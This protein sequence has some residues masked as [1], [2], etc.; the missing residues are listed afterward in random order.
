MNE[1]MCQCGHPAS[2]HATCGCMV[3]IHKGGLRGI[4]PCLF[5]PKAEET[6]AATTQL[7][8]AQARITT[9]EAALREI[10]TIA[11]TIPDGMLDR[12][13]NRILATTRAALDI[14]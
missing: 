13:A 1:I 11:N 3:T 6:N 10:E 2:K 7:V 4:C 12:Q 9:L 8:T 5:T 14:P